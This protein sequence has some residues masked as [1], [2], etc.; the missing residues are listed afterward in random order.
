MGWLGA[1]VRISDRL[2]RLAVEPSQSKRETLAADANLYVDFLYDAA[3]HLRS[4]VDR[5]RKA[6]D[7]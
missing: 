1:N 3:K 2:K 5:A 6:L 4:Q 7:R